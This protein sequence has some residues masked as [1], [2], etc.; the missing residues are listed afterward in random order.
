MWMSTGQACEVI[1]AVVARQV[2]TFTASVFSSLL[3]ATCKIITLKVLINFAEWWMQTLEGGHLIMDIRR[4]ERA[5]E[6]TQ[7]TKSE[8]LSC[9]KRKTQSPLKLLILPLHV[10]S[11]FKWKKQTVRL[12][13]LSD[14][15]TAPSPLLPTAEEVDLWKLAVYH[16]TQSFGNFTSKIW[17]ADTQHKHKK[18]RNE[19]IDHIV[20]LIYVFLIFFG[21]T[22][23][24]YGV[25]R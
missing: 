2:W 12:L 9:M 17:V 3:P 6:S 18:H 10:V 8:G 21:T 16:H 11:D 14:K 15:H 24:L 25:I 19:G 13:I 23:E 20:W 7:N 4:K 22:M 5:Q 1:D